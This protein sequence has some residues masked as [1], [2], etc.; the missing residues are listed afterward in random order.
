[1]NILYLFSRIYPAQAGIDPPLIDDT[2][3]EAD[4]LP[5]KPPRLDL[6]HKLCRF[7][8]Y[9]QIRPVSLAGEI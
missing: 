8:Q 9:V 4:A 1:M 3:Y 2:S 5:T 6:M 7:K